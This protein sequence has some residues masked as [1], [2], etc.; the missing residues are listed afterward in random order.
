MEFDDVADHQV[1]LIQN[2]MGID[3]EDDQMYSVVSQFVCVNPTT[4]N[5][6]PGLEYELFTL[7][8][9][10][11]AY[12]EEEVNNFKHVCTPMCGPIM[13]CCANYH[14]CPNLIQLEYGNTDYTA[15]VA[16]RP[17]HI[18]HYI[19]RMCARI[20]DSHLM[21]YSGGLSSDD[22]D[23]LKMATALVGQSIVISVVKKLLARFEAKGILKEPGPQSLMTALERHLVVEHVNATKVKRLWCAENGHGQYDY[24]NGGWELETQDMLRGRVQS[25]LLYRSMIDEFSK[26]KD[27]SYEFCQAVVKPKEEEDNNNEDNKENIPPTIQVNAV[28]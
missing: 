20:I 9:M 19:V 16:N 1:T 6:E 18:K 8:E 12:T 27:Q 26:D 21:N 11:T 22:F 5:Q 4:G 10:T 17:D 7:D 3:P 24:D 14:I 13:W 25:L 15:F 2:E 28:E 23:R